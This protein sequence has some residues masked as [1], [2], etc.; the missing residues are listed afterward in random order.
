VTTER[1]TETLLHFCNSAAAKDLEA[2][3]VHARTGWLKDWLVEHLPEIVE[4]GDSPEDIDRYIQWDL[5]AKEMMAGRGLEKPEQ[6]KNRLTDIRNAI[7]TID[8]EHPAL[9]YIG[10]TKE[11]WEKINRAGDDAVAKRPTL[12]IENP[13]AIVEKAE[14]LL[15]SRDWYDLAAGLAVLTGR[16]CAEVMKTAVFEYRTPYSVFFTGSLK[17]RDE[18]V[19]PVFEI[20]TLCKAERVIETIAKLRAWIPT[21]GMTNVQINNRYAGAV[22]KSCDRHFTG[23]VPPREDEDG[24]DNNLYTHL[25]R[26]VYATIAAHWFCP[27]RVREGEFKA[28][29]QGHFQVTNENDPTLRN[30][31]SSGR[32]Y[33]DYAIGDGNG[34]RDGRLGI[35]LGEPDIVVVEAF[36]SFYRPSIP[37]KTGDLDNVEGTESGEFMESSEK[38]MVTSS[39]A[40]VT[41]RS[42]KSTQKK[43]PKSRKTE[44]SGETESETSHQLPLPLLE[45]TS[46]SVPDIQEI[47]GWMLNSRQYTV[48]LVGLM[49]VT[50][51]SPGELI[52]SGVFKPD[53]NRSTLTFS[54]SLSK[55]RDPL[56]T[57]L[58]PGVV[59]TALSR[60]RNHKSVQPLRYLSPNEIDR[61]CFPHVVRT[62]HSYL[63]FKD[64]G[65]LLEYYRSEAARLSETTIAI[66]I[67]PVGD[68]EAIDTDASGGTE[69]PTDTGTDD[70]AFSLPR[71]TT[72]DAIDV[73][74]IVGWMLDSDKYTLLLVA[75]MTATGRSAGE[76]IRSRIFQLSDD[77]SNL[78]FAPSSNAPPFLL[79]TVFPA[80]VI[81]KAIVR[82]REHPRVRPLDYLSGEEIDRYC[83]R[84]VTRVLHLYLPFK[85]IGELFDYYRS[86]AVI[87]IGVDTSPETVSPTDTEERATDGTV[88]NNDTFI[89]GDAPPINITEPSAPEVPDEGVAIGT[90]ETEPDAVETGDTTDF[91]WAGVARSIARSLG[92][93]DPDSF[94]SWI[95]EQL[96]PDTDTSP[97]TD[98]GEG[99]SEPNTPNDVE[100]EPIPDK[101]DSPRVPENPKPTI[102]TPEPVAGATIPET[103][104]TMTL[105]RMFLAQQRSLDQLTGAIFQLVNSLASSPPRSDRHRSTP[106][107]RVPPD[108][109]QTTDATDAGGTAEGDTTEKRS[110]PETPDSPRGARI[111]PRGKT[112]PGRPPN[113]ALVNRAIDSIINYNDSIASSKKDRWLISLSV[114]KQLTHCNQE[115]IARVMERRKDQID[116]HH[117]KHELGTF[118]NS[119]GKFAPK[120]TEV[121]KVE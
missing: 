109:S 75:L 82:L 45:E 51:R 111:T 47:V 116:R 26:A 85:D 94:R 91:R 23:L 22:I 92:I 101:P 69:T 84:R 66:E 13:I 10:F 63:P 49:T 61:H 9:K 31:I 95:E 17:R 80:G 108:N 1:Q 27:P 15:N 4:G 3:L 14:E 78:T 83:K 46:A 59:S 30:N 81:L 118:H 99:V 33:S 20:P 112:S 52:K 32:H 18:K 37:E 105:E 114:L 24:K 103:G 35:R 89:G 96:P 93:D 48:L 36:Q 70:R 98:N 11:E 107:E 38:R 8:P 29:I 21:E 12:F 7:K 117:K 115:V 110:T 56:P 58:P 41:D 16:R 102:A 68:G 54:N 67:P 62:L 28:Y 42:G 43:S 39:D 73:R 87:S 106:R 100:S 86:V 72:A 120:I 65:E 34:N 6:Q 119:K 71:E 74:D 60:L 55:T 40:D 64:V 2:A 90:T 50:G 57:L 113:E 19:P 121:I 53:R 88:L 77:R 44:P 76:L 79:P 97:A 25:F 104:E 5:I